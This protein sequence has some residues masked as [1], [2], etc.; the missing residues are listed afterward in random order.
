MNLSMKIHVFYNES[1]A[2]EFAFYVDSTRIV[3][4]S[5]CVNLLT[6]AVHGIC[7]MPV[8]WCSCCVS[9]HMNCRFFG[10]GDGSQNLESFTCVTLIEIPLSSSSSSVIVV[11]LVVSS[12]INELS[13]FGC[14]FCFPTLRQL[15]LCEL[16]QFSKLDDDAYIILFSFYLKINNIIGLSS[17]L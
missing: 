6:A 8:Y 10:D 7:C 3:M 15:Q 13:F 14:F 4:P 9:C 1:S 16:N 5:S 2:S 17:L 12:A 11:S